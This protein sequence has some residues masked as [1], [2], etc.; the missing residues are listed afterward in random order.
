MSASNAKQRLADVVVGSRGWLHEQ[1]SE[2]YYPEDIPDEWRLGF[3]ANEFNT[4]LV[5]WAQ[6]N[7]SIEA[8][9][10]GL[11]DADDDFHLYLE[12]PDTQQ[13]LPK[14]WH[15]IADQVKGLVCTQGD[16]SQWVEIAENIGVPLLVEMQNESVFIG[17]APYGE[18]SASI[19]LA[20]IDGT[21]IDD[22]VLMREQIEQALQLADSRLDFIFTDTA[23]A[24]DAM[25][26]T[27]MIAELLGA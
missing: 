5:P 24:L 17:Y 23:P 26:N 27:V 7:E 20:M 13:S 9:E 18:A 21:K 11:E 22:L 8:L 4:L 25:R 19:E 10:E 2:S 3:Y 14:H 15:V 6:W 16:A 1:W 12:L